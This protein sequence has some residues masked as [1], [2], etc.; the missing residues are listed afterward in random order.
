MGRRACLLA[1]LSICGDEDECLRAGIPRDGD[2]GFGIAAR[3]DR[4]FDLR[5]PRGVAGVG[6]WLVY[7][8]TSGGQQC[9]IEMLDIVDADGRERRA[10][11]QDRNHERAI[12]KDDALEAI[13][14]YWWCL[15]AGNR[16][17]AGR[18]ACLDGELKVAAAVADPLEDK[19]GALVEVDAV[20]LAGY[21]A[22]APRCRSDLP[23]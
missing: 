1:A 8:P 15:A 13:T 4:R 11:A 16:R 17:C 19:P 9:L 18:N 7:M 21:G 5:R 10:I 2:G 23:A 14:A 20:S 6:E 12:W 22:V 3:D